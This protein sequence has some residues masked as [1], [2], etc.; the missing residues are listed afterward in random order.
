[1]KPKTKM[2][3]AGGHLRRHLLLGPGDVVVA[4]RLL[5]DDVAH[6][7]PGTVGVVFAAVNEYGGGGGPMVRWMNMGCCNVYPGDVTLI[8]GG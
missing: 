4:A 7:R 1:M 6:V 2:M 5:K 8:Y 3:L